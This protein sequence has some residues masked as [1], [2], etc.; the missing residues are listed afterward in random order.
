[1]LE[2]LE[3]HGILTLPLR[4]GDSVRDA[5]AADRPARTSA[6]DP[7]CRVYISLHGNVLLRFAQRVPPAGLEADLVAQ[8]GAGQARLAGPPGAPMAFG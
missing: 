5:R 7:R 2:T 6:S 4:R 8:R 3:S 1:M